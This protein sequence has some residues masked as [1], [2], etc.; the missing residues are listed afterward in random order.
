MNAP[1]S[2]YKILLNEDGSVIT[3]DGEYLG[4]WTEDDLG[5]FLY[6]TPE[7]KTE[8]MFVGPTKWSLGNQI[9]GWHYGEEEGGGEN[10]WDGE[11]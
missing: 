2:Y 8:T 6:F 3:S 11:H 1:R 4:R 9:E 7:G 5:N 10:A